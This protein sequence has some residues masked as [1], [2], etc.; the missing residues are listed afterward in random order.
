MHLDDSAVEADR[1]QPSPDQLLG[2]QA[3]EHAIDGLGDGSRGA[4]IVI[5]MQKGRVCCSAMLYTDV[6]WKKSDSP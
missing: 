1:L 6:F 2:L 3:R 4:E 5:L